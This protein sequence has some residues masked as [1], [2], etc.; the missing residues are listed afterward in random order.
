MATEGSNLGVTTLAQA[1]KMMAPDGSILPIAEILERSTPI[2]K[3]A[4]FMQGNL[5]TGHRSGIRTGYP[6]PTWRELYGGIQPSTGIVKQVTDDSA[7]LTALSQVDMTLLKLEKDKGAFL[8]KKAGEHL[9]GMGLEAEEQLIY[10]TEADKAKFKG[11]ADRYKTLS[12]DKNKIGY[13][14]LNAGGSGST[15][16]SIWM[17]CWGSNLISGFYP[18]GTKAG[19]DQQNFEPRMVDAPVGEG[20]YLAQETLFTWNLGLTVMDWRAVVRIANIDATELADAGESSYNGAPLIN[21]MIKAW[22]RIPAQVK[23]MSS[24]KAIYANE[25]VVTAL[26]LIANNK[27]YLS[28]KVP[29]VGQEPW[30]NFRGVPIKQA[31]KILDTEETI[32]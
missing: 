26:D 12:T 7:E 17:V 31:E 23:A 14:V 11:L 3:D 10:G 8:M 16:T 20:R 15:N 24:S 6:S 30:V 9:I 28:L 29:E 13:N 19:I 21:L 25:T 1:A 32:V 5:K 27:S 18:D 22:N 2:I 4:P